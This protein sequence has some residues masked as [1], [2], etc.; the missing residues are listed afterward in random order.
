MMVCFV[1]LVRPG[2]TIR[3]QESDDNVLAFSLDVRGPGFWHNGHTRG[4][5]LGQ[6]CANLFAARVRDCWHIRYLAL[7]K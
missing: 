6:Y 4:G 7:Y 2:Y 3:V 1:S 5:S